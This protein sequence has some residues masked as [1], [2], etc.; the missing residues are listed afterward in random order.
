MKGCNHKKDQG[1]IWCHRCG[2]ERAG[3]KPAKT[4]E[5]GWYVLVENEDEPGVVL[6]V[7][8]TL[9]GLAVEKQR[10][11]EYVTVRVAGIEW[12]GPAERLTRLVAEK[13]KVKA[14]VHETTREKFV[15]DLKHYSRNLTPD[16]QINVGVTPSLL[17]GS[18]ALLEEQHK[19]IEE[20]RK[21]LEDKETPKSQRF[22]KKEVQQAARDIKAEG[23]RDLDAE[24][25]VVSDE[26]PCKHV[27]VS[28]ATHCRLCGEPSE[29]LKEAKRKAEKVASELLLYSLNLR[30]DIQQETSITPSLLRTAA[31]MLMNSTPRLR[32]HCG[33]DP[34]AVGCCGGTDDSCSCECSTCEDPR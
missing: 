4:I 27:F 14:F 22:T 34:A 21:S 12:K 11:Q 18:A 1:C 31:E 7:E 19:E 15:F 24:T 30:A 8:H 23:L 25:Y 3:A 2:S 28:G 20:L 17:L 10:W 9:L 16:F 32:S 13:K 26:T 29:A 5:K 6:F 33:R